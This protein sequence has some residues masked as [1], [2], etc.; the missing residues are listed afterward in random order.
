MPRDGLT[1]TGAPDVLVVDNLSLFRRRPAAAPRRACRC[2]RWPSGFA[3]PRGGGAGGGSSDAL[4]ALDLAAF[5]GPAPVT[6]STAGT[7]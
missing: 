2:P 1:V 3:A 6:P 7:G 5:A 4:A